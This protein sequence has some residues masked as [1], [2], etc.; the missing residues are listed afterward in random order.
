MTS[1]EDTPFWKANKFDLIIP[2]SLQKLLEVYRAGAPVNMPYTSDSSYN[3]LFEAGFDRFW[4][5]SNYVAILTG[6]NVLP[7]SSLP[8]LEHKKESLEKAEV[9]FELIKYST[10]K[11]LNELPS[12]YEYIKRL[13]NKLEFTANSS[14]NRLVSG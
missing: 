12:H 10:E 3:K 4:T 6:M 9:A 5:N 7:D 8:V 2:D 1:R 11:L 14:F 13:H